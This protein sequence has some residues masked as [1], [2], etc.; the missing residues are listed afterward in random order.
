MYER[1]NLVSSNL[2]LVHACAWRF[3]GKG[4]EYDDLY[5]AGCMGLVKAADRFDDSRGFCFSTYAVPVIIGEIK[6]LFRDGGSVRISRSLKE[7]AMKARRETDDYMKKSGREPTIQELA[8]KLEVSPEQVTEALCASA[9]TVSLSV[10]SDGQEGI[11]DIPVDAPDE[12]ITELL[13]LKAE[14]SRLDSNDRELIRLRFFSSKT[15]TETA[16]YLGM[17]QVQ[18]SRR[19]KKLL[20]YLRQRLAG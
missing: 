16:R 20:L 7:L 12:R 3:R 5:Q 10:S 1:E 19:E 8:Q 4:I 14:L 15:Q 17:T 13:S 18:V 11:M 2:G 9:P 6:R